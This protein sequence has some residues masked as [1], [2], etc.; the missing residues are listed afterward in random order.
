MIGLCTVHSTVPVCPCAL[1]CEGVALHLMY[2]FPYWQPG[3]ILCN[4]VVSSDFKM[5][6]PELKT[7]ISSLSH[8]LEVR[9]IAQGSLKDD[10]AIRSL[11]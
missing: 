11:K 8:G 6:T 2:C 1:K 3:M 7:E 9:A 10:V 5:L 4:T